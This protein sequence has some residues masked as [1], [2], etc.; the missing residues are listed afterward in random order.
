[1]SA[2]TEEDKKNAYPIMYQRYASLQK[3]VLSI[4]DTNE[5]VTW[6]QTIPFEMFAFNI[7]KKLNINRSADEIYADVMQRSAINKELITPEVEEKFKLFMEYF[8]VAIPIYLDKEK[9]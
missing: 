2:I 5:W 4:D 7:G 3:F 6:L 8:S 1:M 9:K